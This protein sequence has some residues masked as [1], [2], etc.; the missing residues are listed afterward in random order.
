[1][2]AL[3]SS[4]IFIMAAQVTTR[5]LQG[6]ILDNL[7]PVL[8]LSVAVILLWIGGKG[9]NAGAARR[10]V[11]LLI[12]LMALG[13]AVSGKAPEIGTFLAGLLTGG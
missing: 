2:T 4:E 5:G 9:D 8:L 11:G 13:I 7:V 1:M 6:W 12:G 10:S 3:G